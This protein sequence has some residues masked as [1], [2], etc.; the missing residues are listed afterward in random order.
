[1]TQSAAQP[2]TT[3]RWLVLVAVIVSMSIMAFEAT[4]V[5]TAMP[6]IVSD[7]GGLQLYSWVFSAYLLTQTALTVVFGKLADI[8]GRRP[9]VLAGI[10]VFLLGSLLAGFAWSMP[11]MIAFRLIQGIGAG[12]LQP[13]AMTVISDLYP[14]AERAK[15]QAY[16]ASVWAVSA[17]AGPVI[18]SVIVE[19]LSWP[20]IFWINI[21]VGIGATLLYLGFLR[22]DIRHRAGSV[23]FLGAILSAIAVASL[24]LLLTEAGTAGLGFFAVA[25]TVCVAASVLFVWQERR[26]PDPMVHFALWRSRPIATANGVSFLSNMALIGLTTCL[27]IYV[28]AVMGESALVAG[29]TLTVLMIGWPAGATV[30]ARLFHTVGPRRLI[31]GGS[32]IMPLGPYMLMFLNSGSPPVLAGTAS[33][34]MGFGMGLMSVSALMVIQGAVEPQQRGSA[35]ASVLFARNLGGTLGA[36]VLGAIL[37]IGL[38]QGGHVDG[39]QLRRLLQHLDGGVTTDLAA[40]AVLDG[41]LHLSFTAMLVIAVATIGTALLIPVHIPGLAAPAPEPTVGP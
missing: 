32:L 31:I 4:I 5:S 23:D 20:W 21:P 25:G 30:A 37:N 26:A 3:T 1:M 9:V 8:Y 19:Y 15:I 16:L 29:L 41:A 2:K 12:A 28:Q 18:G 38:S 36:A 24:M 34:L 17:I 27:P 35:T 40:R 14:G 11:S 6:Q 13:A 7:L 22:T 10:A 33:L 39:E